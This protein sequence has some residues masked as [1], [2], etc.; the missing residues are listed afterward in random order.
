MFE[1]IPTKN[2]IFLG[3]F[4]LIAGASTFLILQEIDKRTE[5]RIEEQ[6]KLQEEAEFEAIEMK[7]D[8]LIKE[9]EASLPIEPLFDP[10]PPPD[11]ERIKREGCVA[12]GLLNGYSK[13]TEEA[14][15]LINRSNCYYLHRSVE[16]WLETPDFEE[17]KE[18]MDKIKKED[19]VYGMFIAEAI[20]TKADYFYE[21]RNREF[22]FSRMCRDGS[23]NAWGE[24]TCKPTLSKNEYQRYVKY[25]AR[26][27]MDLGVQVFMFGQIHYQ[28]SV[29]DPAV[30]ETID[31]MR[32]YANLR[33]LEILI[34]AQTND[35]DDEDYLRQ[36][37][38]IEGGVGINSD[39]RIENGPCFSRWY[40]KPGDWCWALLW[41]DRFRS[42]ANNVIVHL[43]WSGIKG[44][45]MSI[46]AN[47]S[48]EK[49]AETLKY[50]DD[51][52]EKRDVGFLM[53]MIAVLHKE[54]GGCHG[55]SRK[56]YSASN[57]YSCKDEDMINELLS[58]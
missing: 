57:K 39:G 29:S 27:A 21:T 23:K 12:D 40:K 51:Y 58:D 49:R 45:D 52:F 56:Y 24:H 36:F 18:T 43:D 11:M 32:A 4:L 26:K 47:M 41:H 9:R 10:P 22:D 38:F 8:K 1:K 44:D 42:R 31:S 14:V 48:R 46:F 28:D 33:G 55:E 3:I 7:Y 17:I 35:I 20:D 53:P 13:G 6:K 2:W 15:K 25:I 5:I 19:I 30:K 37:D 50:L 54:N 34:G 16:T